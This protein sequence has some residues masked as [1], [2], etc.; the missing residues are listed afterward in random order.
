MSK[1][2]RKTDRRFSAFVVVIYVL[3]AIPV[4]LVG[5]PILLA[6]FLLAL[7]F[8][9][10]FFA[11]TWVNRLAQGVGEQRDDPVFGTLTYCGASTWYGTCELPELGG[12]FSISV[13]GPPKIGPGPAQHEHFRELVARQSDIRQQVQHS[14]F[15]E[16][17]QVA[18]EVRKD[19]ESFADPEPFLKQI[20]VLTDP[21]QI[22][23]LMS[24][25]SIQLDDKPGCFSLFWNCT[26]DEEHGFD[27]VFVDWKMQ[28]DRSGGV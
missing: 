22:W 26:W 21:A 20:P 16:Y 23:T 5:L 2:T 8:Y 1:S 15:R 12:M 24:D 17:L 28:D 19:F 10:V 6:I 27:R 13:T 3:L 25:G 7:P 11:I 14:I 9:V 18:P 4:I